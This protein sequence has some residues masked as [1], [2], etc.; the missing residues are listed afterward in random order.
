M[1]KERDPGGGREGKEGEG[2]GWQMTGSSRFKVYTHTPTYPPPSPPA[3]A[4]LTPP[5]PCPPAP[6]P[7]LTCAAPD[8]TNTTTNH[9]C[10]HTSLPPSAHLLPDVRQVL[11]RV[12][13]I[14]DLLLVLVLRHLLLRGLIVLAAHLLLRVSNLLL[15]LRTHHLAL[16]VRA[17]AAAAAAVDGEPNV[18][19]GGD[20]RKRLERG[21]RGQ[22]DGGEG[23]E[24]AAQG[25]AAWR[26]ADGGHVERMEAVR[27]PSERD[28]GG[29]E[30]DVVREVVLHVRDKPD[31]V[32]EVDVNEAGVLG[33][34]REG[35]KGGGGGGGGVRC[36]GFLRGMF[37]DKWLCLL[38][39]ILKV[40]V[41]VRVGMR[42]KAGACLKE[43]ARLRGKEG[44]AH[45][46]KCV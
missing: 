7:A 44:H 17:A 29:A 46:C 26:A 22:G 13:G 37:E 11:P 34:G 10:G 39:A 15:V 28:G 23:K 43:G 21:G 3:T 30:R 27:G 24:I 25:P 38:V 35:G 42:V 12:L 4:G 1:E 16:G 9:T 41:T 40:R 2:A 31:L 18:G 19:L 5:L 20:L 36:P 8:H 45:M 33:G 6:P 32:R 14:L